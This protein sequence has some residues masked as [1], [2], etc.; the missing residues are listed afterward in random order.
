[1]KGTI[2]TFFGRRGLGQTFDYSSCVD[3]LIHC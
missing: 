1:M 3:D 2:Y